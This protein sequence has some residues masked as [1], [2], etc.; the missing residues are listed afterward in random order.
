MPLKTIQNTFFF[1]LVLLVTGAFVFLLQDFF[2]PLLWA[3]ILAIIFYPVYRRL[4]SHLGGRRSVSA[5][6]TLLLIIVVVIAPI[7]LVGVAVTEEITDFYQRVVAGEI[8]LQEPIE[9]AE[10]TLPLVRDYMDRMGVDVPRIRESLSQAAVTGSRYL[11]SRVLSIGQNAIRFSILFFLMLYLLFFFLRDGERLINTTIR[12][13]P[14]GDEREQQ[15][16]SRF[17]EVSRATIKGTLV[18][19]LVQGVLGG[20]LFWILGLEAALFWGILMTL[21][22]LLPAVGAALIWA[23]AAIILLVTGEVVKGLI[24]L[25]TGTL[26]IGLV[27]NLLRPVLVGRDTEMPD[28]LIL[29]STL[30]GLTVFGISGFVIGPVIA[31][32]FLA[33]WEMFMKEYSHLDDRQVPPSDGGAP[34]AKAA[35]EAEQ[36]SSS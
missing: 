12:A 23:P 24:L 19:G 29:L 17:A 3:S 1:G 27:D 13:L 10:R 21:L 28:Y 32:L 9:T 31:A 4:L 26:I 15:L 18:V 11:A 36:A 22:A 16:L 8:D 20:L 7:F 35:V 5:A 30:G 33:V 14:L 34:E 25:V 6:C 2:Q